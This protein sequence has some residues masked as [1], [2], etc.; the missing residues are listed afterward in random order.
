MIELMNARSRFLHEES[1]FFEGFLTKEGLIRRRSLCAVVYIYGMAEAVNILMET[2]KAKQGAM[3]TMNKQISCVSS[4]LKSWPR[5]LK[6]L[7]KYGL[8]QA[9][10]HAQGGISLDE[11]KKTP[12]APVSFML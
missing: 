9:L 7:A 3:V 12:G 10:L 5:L 2:K 1:N 4:A 11:D 6:I 8:K